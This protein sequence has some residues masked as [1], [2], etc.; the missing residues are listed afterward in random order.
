MSKPRFEFA[1]LR[2]LLFGLGF[3]EVPVNTPPG[4]T[5]PQVGFQHDDSDLLIVLPSYRSRSSVAPHHLVYVRM[6]LDGKGLM[7]ADEFD[8]LVG[9][10][11]TPRSA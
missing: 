4:V 1:S 7:E 9:N 6:M 2:Q 8:R 10:V 5:K 11:P 3:K